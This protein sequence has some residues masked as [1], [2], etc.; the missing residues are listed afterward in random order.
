MIGLGIL[1]FLGIWALISVFLARLILKVIDSFKEPLK[2]AGQIGV[3]QKSRSVLVQLVLATAIFVLPVID[4][5][6]AYPKWQELCGSTGDFEWG[7]SMDEKKVFGREVFTSSELHETS[8]FPGIR[9]SYFDWNVYDA[10][11]KQL[12]FTKPH[13]S[14][15]AQAL[16]H[17]PSSSGDKKALLLKTCE[18]L[19]FMTQQ[20]NL[21]NQLNLTQVEDGEN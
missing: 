21:L 5:V 7:P 15:S 18:N 8:I 3:W 12:I 2:E 19:K 9:V 11:S 20:D 1:L 13:Y 10:V 17:L 4:Q 14:Y 16:I 6:I